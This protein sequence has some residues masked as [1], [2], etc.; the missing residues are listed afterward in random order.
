MF[1]SLNVE[2]IFGLSLLTKQQTCLSL[3]HE[4]NFESPKSGLPSGG[5]SV[6]LK[7]FNKKR[8]KSSES[9]GSIVSRVFFFATKKN[10]K[11][12]LNELFQIF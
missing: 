8:N 7:C 4:S 6:Q 5:A 2:F 11:V 1:E 3:L 12:P 9:R 10:F